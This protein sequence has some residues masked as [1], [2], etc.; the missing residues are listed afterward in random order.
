MSANQQNPLKPLTHNQH[1]AQNG[2]AAAVKNTYEIPKYCTLPYGEYA[3]LRNVLPSGFRSET[4]TRDIGIDTLC[5]QKPCD[6]TALRMRSAPVITTAVTCFPPK[7]ENEECEATKFR[8]ICTR[9]HYPLTSRQP[10]A[11]KTEHHKETPRRCDFPMREI[12][13]TSLYCQA[14]ISCYS[15]GNLK[16]TLRCQNTRRW[17]S[18]W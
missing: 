6:R 13:C 12:N 2:V 14:V 9:D 15:H 4:C 3:E 11:V 1:S 5:F 17:E 7:K 18:S 16:L 8:T 10:G